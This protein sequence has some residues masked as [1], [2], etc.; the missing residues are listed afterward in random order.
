MNGYKASHQHK[1]VIL[2]GD[3]DAT[4]IESMNTVMDDN[5]VLTLVSNERIPFTP[6]MRMILEIQDMKHASPATVSRGG[7]LFINET[8]IGWKPYVESWREKMDQIPQGAF[9]LHF[10]N[11]FEANIEAIRKSFNFSCPMLDMGFINSLT[12]FI[13]ALLNN[14]TKEN[15]E[16]LR[17]MSPEDQKM[18][19][20]ALFCYAMMWTIGGSIADDKTVN[21]RKSFNAYMKGL[22]KAVRFPDQG[23]CYDFIYEPKAKDWVSWETYI[24]PYQPLAE[25]MY[26]NIVISNMELERM[27]YILELHVARKKPVLFVGVAGTGKTTIVKDYLADMKANN[28]DMISMSINNNNYTSSFALQNIIMSALDKRSGRTFGPPANKKCVFFI[29]DLNMPYVD[30]Y[31]TQSAIM[32]LTQMLAY[33]QVYDRAALED[34]RDLVDILFTACMNPKAREYRTSAF[35]LCFSLRSL[36]PNSESLSA[37]V[38]TDFVRPYLANRC[39]GRFLHG[40]PALAE[41]IHSAYHVPQNHIGGRWVTEFC[42]DT[43]MI[44]QRAEV[45]SECAYHFRNL[46]LHSGAASA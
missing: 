39:P 45:H 23:D 10:S 30:T 7:V 21:Y 2:D 35:E 44:K 17:T 26:Q 8:D 42:L 11:Y 40:E 32:L 9:Y 4:W 5:K 25:Q 18:S 22:S 31:D 6:T 19:Y 36:P 29:D 34:K 37:R 38:L 28:E 24:K 14:N 12:C 16:A 41:A 46:Q 43:R 15:M 33:S 27:K 1:W 13:D 20:D 3:I